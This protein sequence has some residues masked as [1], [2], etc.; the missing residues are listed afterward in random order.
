MNRSTDS[1]STDHSLSRGFAS[2]FASIFP[3]ALHLILILALPTALLLPSS[4]SLR[5]RRLVLGPD[6]HEAVLSLFRPV[7]LGGEVAQGYRLWNVEIGESRIECGLV[8][9]ELPAVQVIFHGKLQHAQENPD[10]ESVSFYIEYSG[11]NVSREGAAAQKALAQFVLKNDNGSLLRRSTSTANRSFTE[12]RSPVVYMLWALFVLITLLCRQGLMDGFGA[13]LALLATTLFGAALRHVLSEPVVMGAW[14]FSRRPA[15]QWAL[16]EHPEFAQFISILHPE[17]LYYFD[18]VFFVAFVV[19]TLTIP[20]VYAHCRLLTGMRTTALFAAFAFATLPLHIR[21]SKTEVAFVPSLALSSATFYLMHCSIK[22]RSI[23]V[24]VLALLSLPGLSYAAFHAR[25]LNLIFYPLLICAALVLGLRYSK[26]TRAML[27][28]LPAVCLLT[29]AAVPSVVH[30]FEGYDREIGEALSL[31]TVISGLISLFNLN[32]NTL[33]NPTV[34]PIALMI[35]AGFALLR[36]SFETGVESRD[37]QRVL[38]FLIGWILL[39]FIAHAYVLPSSLAMQARYHLHLIVPFVMIAALGWNA[40][41][42]MRPRWAWALIL[43]CG[44]SPL[45]HL[46]FIRDVDYLDLQEFAFAT[47]ARDALP[48]SCAV[49]EYL[50][51]RHRGNE[52]FRHLGMY[53]EEGQETQ[54]FQSL[55]LTDYASARE[56]PQDGCVAYYEGLPCY[57][58]K[59]HDEPIDP[60]CLA[61]RDSIDSDPVLQRVVSVRPYDGNLSGGFASEEAEA[62]F[63]LYRLR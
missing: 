38:G 49:V 24:R 34:T 26:S 4:V 36:R 27:S 12:N 50:P 2:R 14:P 22:D 28:A 46:R 35:C 17:P 8:H 1:D 9:S 20:L 51:D 11:Q 10:E 52:R 41:H 7:E 18:F 29:A 6:L 45:L 39:F 15:L 25:P 56:V 23:L 37:E 3:K 32:Y 5:D 16:W 60:K 43:M 40:L 33:I 57:A 63:R 21:F 19:G 62:E 31:H 44:L 58:A 61:F 30:L 54:R 59:N 13:I 42:R 53:L 47:Q 48:D 55:A